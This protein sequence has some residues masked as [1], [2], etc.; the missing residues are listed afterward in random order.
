ME[1]I[2]KI[3]FRYVTIIL[4]SVMNLTAKGGAINLVD[5]VHAIK[6]FMAKV[7]KFL[8]NFVLTRNT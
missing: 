7:V 1:W 2:V 3:N 6:D 8:L 5:N 4:I